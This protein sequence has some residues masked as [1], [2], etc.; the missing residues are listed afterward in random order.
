MGFPRQEYW[1]GM[2]FPSPGDLPYTGIEP[3]SLVLA[4]RFFI[5]EPPG[6]PITYNNEYNFLCV[7]LYIRYHSKPFTCIIP[8]ISSSEPWK[9]ITLSPLYTNKMQS[10]DHCPGNNIQVMK[11]ASDPTD[12]RTFFLQYTA[13]PACYK[14]GRVHLWMSIL[15]Y[16]TGL[17]S[18][19]SS[20]TLGSW[21]CCPPGKSTIHFAP[22]ADFI[23]I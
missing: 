5:T 10:L 12:F 1:S 23:E 18:L 22:R 2:P 20:V 21:F 3:A 6:K 14:W 4:G 17:L 7:L 11:T 15:S 8:F 19:S 9:S 13:I 16:F